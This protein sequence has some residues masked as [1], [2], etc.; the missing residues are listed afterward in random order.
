MKILFVT[1]GFRQITK[2]QG[3]IE[4]L[5]NIFILNNEKTKKHE[6]TVYS[7]SKQGLTEDDIYTNTKFRNIDL[8]AKKNKV[9]QKIISGINRIVPVK[10]SQIYIKK[11]VDDL[12][13]RKEEN[14]YDI[15]IMENGQLYIRYFKEKMNTKS[16]I[17]LHLHNDVLNVSTPYAKKICSLFDEIWTVS[18][19][20]KSRVDE[21]DSN[22]SKK[23]KI[24]Y[25]TIDFSYFSNKLSKKEIITLRE[26]YGCKKN[27]FVFI[28]VGR[29]IEGKGVLELLEIFKRI[30]KKYNNTKL[31]IVGGNAAFTQTGKYYQK[32]IKSKNENVIL[33]G[34]INYNELYKYYQ[35]A[36]VQVIPSICYEAFGLIALEGVA[37]NIPIIC[38]NRGGL[39]EVLSECCEYIDMDNLNDSLYKLM[40]KSINN[41]KNL[42]EK[43]SDYN[44]IVAKFSLE[45]YIN[46]MEK[47]LYSVKDGD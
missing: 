47:Y 45:N 44:N 32:I 43:T 12:L 17:V 21:I 2:N 5:I 40:E 42:L 26:K 18:E 29:V 23:T 3:A 35:I 20:I 30:N 19:Y 41:Y 16:K 7:A 36:D 31:I 8:S 34:N 25:N 9:F 24:L 15:I 46:C 10:M 22:I 37:C 28:Y 27:D 6:I 39:P 4:N 33:T 14:Y 1:S 11:V 38:S 13:L